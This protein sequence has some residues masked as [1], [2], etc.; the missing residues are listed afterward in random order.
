MFYC[1]KK[2]LENKYVELVRFVVST[3][4]DYTHLVP[5]QYFTTQEDLSKLYKNK[6]LSEQVYFIEFSVRKSSVHA[7]TSLDI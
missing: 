4:V 1:M 6:V 7:K 5:T 2:C 3:V